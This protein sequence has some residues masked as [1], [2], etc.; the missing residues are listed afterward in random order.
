M[1][2]V[3][4][5]IKNAKIGIFFFGLSILAQFFSRK[6]FLE[7]LG[8][9]FMGLTGTLRSMLSFLNL[10]ELGI[11]TAIGYTLYKPIFD[12]DKIEINKV[13]GLLGFLYQ[14]IGLIVLGTGVVASLFFPWIFND[15]S[16]SIGL[17]YFTFFSF[18]A[19]TL[20]SYFVNYHMVLLE[21]DQKGYVVQG[22]FQTS[23]IIRLI[24]QSLVSYYF[25]SLYV[26]V[27]LELFFSILYCIILRIKVK[28]HYPWLTIRANE[29]KN[30]I[31]EYPEVIKNIKQLFVHKIGSFVKDGTDNILVFALVSLE[32]VAFFGNYQ[33]IFT[34]LTGLV[35]MVFSGTRAGIGNLVAENNM[36]NIFKVFWEIQALQFFIGGVLGLV[37]YHCIE[38]FITIWVGEEYILDKSVLL[39]LVIIFFIGQVR[40]A[41]E[42]FKN[43]Y[44]LFSDTW[45]PAAEAI[46]NL[47]ISFIF[48][49]MLGISGIMLGTLVS[50]VLF[51]VIWK[52][53]FLYKH[54]FKTSLWPY[55][56]GFLGHL[57][58]F[59]SVF[60]GLNHFIQSFINT[61]VNNYGAWIL[62][63]VEITAISAISY[64]LLLYIFATGF[65]NLTY[66][67]I[68]LVSKKISKNGH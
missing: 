51:V 52:P 66:R 4:K 37:L 31:K 46:V 12:N 47:L 49:R 67:V 61:E 2:R 32:S 35:K 25:Q 34:K 55:W 16:L 30:I 63:V 21:A 36:K 59:L 43:A 58:L 17:V 54:G 23:N 5:S 19:T 11:G 57:F 1:S 62:L 65:K 50:L 24:V 42:F 14:R 15:T 44:G 20:F 29:T 48:G 33:L 22:Y 53:Y 64:G 38:P 3:R 8:D 9:E 13:I 60:I 28:E 56:K 45:A 39:L 26:W 7:F 27:A 18:L 40:G 41:V 68:K 6:I 10:A